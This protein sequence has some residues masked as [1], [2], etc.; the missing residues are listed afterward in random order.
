MKEILIETANPQ[1]EVR[2]NAETAVGWEFK[3]EAAYLYEKAIVLRERLIDPIARVDRQQL[4]DPVIG[5][6]NLRN[7]KVLAEYLVIREKEN[8]VHEDIFSKI[9]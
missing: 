3:E 2:R 6:D 8:Q 4:P 7:Y 9:E 1:P 5:F